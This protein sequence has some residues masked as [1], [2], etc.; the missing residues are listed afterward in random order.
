MRLGG[1]VFL[2]A[3]VSCARHDAAEHGNPQPIVLATGQNGPTTGVTVDATT[4]YWTNYRGDSVMKVPLGG[5]T[6]VTLA[7]GQNAPHA[8]A[9]DASFV[10]WASR[11]AILREPLAG[12]APPVTVARA[13]GPNAI[14]VDTANLYWVTPN[15]V[16]AQPVTGGA[17]VAL[18]SANGARTL[19]VHGGSLFWLEYGDG[20]ANRVMTVPIRGGP[21][22]ALA[23]GGN[24]FSSLAVDDT[25]VYWTEQWVGTVAKV[26]VGGGAR[27]TLVPGGADQHGGDIAVDGTWVYWTSRSVMKVPIG[28][29]TPVV[30]APSDSAAA[31]AVDSTSVYWTVG[32]HSEDG[33]SNGKVM[34][35]SK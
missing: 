3:I 14:A 28:G 5:G 9:V 6:P 18:A 32:G 25:N 12:G 24:C 11:D 31:L 27:I 17:P 23:S 2:L 34:K 33:F 8:I 19:V 29:G 13:R 21:P 10:Y 15:A 4:V 7:S 16:W 20:D 30:V 35:T 22:V 26:P 1:A